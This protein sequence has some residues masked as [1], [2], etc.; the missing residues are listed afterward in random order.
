MDFYWMSGSPFAWRAMLALEIKGADYTAHEVHLSK[1][2]TQTPEFLA[3]NPRGK[4]PVLK[5]GDRVIYESNAII[6]YLEHK[7]PNP[8]LLGEDAG[9]I[10]LIHQRAEELNSYLVPQVGPLARFL[11]REDPTVT[12]EMIKAAGNAI[13]DEFGGAARWLE[14]SDFLAGDRPTLPDLILYPYAALIERVV[15]HPKADMIPFGMLPYADKLP[16]LE[17]WRQRIEALPGY[18]KTYPTHWRS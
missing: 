7:Y 14:E 17:A 12:P 3:M 4:V 10:A 9:E 2:D 18:D 15:Q 1:G 8:S 6:A 16:V 13:T 11:F 5:D